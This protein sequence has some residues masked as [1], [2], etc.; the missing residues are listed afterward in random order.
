M[1]KKTLKDI[2]LKDKRVLM[3]VDF[4]TPLVNGKVSDN[5]KIAA[6]LKSIR[7][8]LQHGGRLM[9][10]SHLGRPGGK[11]DIRYSLKPCAQELD[12]LLGMITR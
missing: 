3:R 7:Y 2:D 5:T 8:I 11:V 10:L 1:L 6:G 9:L 12:Y 4:N